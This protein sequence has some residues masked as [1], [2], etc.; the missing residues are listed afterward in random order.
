M[1]GDVLGH[2]NKESGGTMLV[3][4]ADLYGST[5]A[6]NIAKPFPKGF[7]NTVTNP[8]SRMIA[9]GGICEDGMN[10]MVTGI[11]AFGKH[12][13][14]SS[15]YAAFASFGHVAMRLHAIGQQTKQHAFKTNM[16]T[17]IMFNGHAGLPT[18]ED[19]PTHADPQAL[20]LFQE[21]FPKGTCICLT[22]FEV[23]EVWPLV[24]YALSKRPAVLAP[25]VIRASENFV[26]RAA[27]G[28]SKP[29]D[30]M[31]GIYALN[32]VEGEADGSVILQGAGVAKIFLSGV[33]PELK[34][35]G[36]KINV[37]YVSSRELFDMLSKEEQ[38]Q[39]LPYSV[40]EQATAV[41]DF[42][43]PTIADLLCGKTGKDHMLWPHKNGQYL[44]SGKA[45]KLYEEAGLDAKGMLSG[46]LSYIKALKK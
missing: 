13:G 24:T 3:S 33:L 6:G 25:F 16:D 8:Q 4:S 31:K 41:T 18:G 45:A 32:R 17:V 42:T 27:I 43:P 39:I 7:F 20:Q 35:Q 22:P 46:I 40:R 15:S 26:D 5:N 21:N 19:G 36:L 23:D 37:F 1:L 10:A 12:I 9:G 29:E 28:Q 44:G 30:T 14:V 11:S 38:E 2:I 34:N